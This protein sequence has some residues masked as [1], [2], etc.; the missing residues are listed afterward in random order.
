MCSHKRDQNKRKKKKE[1][2]REREREKD[3]LRKVRQ[4]KGGD[5]FHFL[6]ETEII[7]AIKMNW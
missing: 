2:E 4:I 5:S 6:N 1:N 3:F 7:V